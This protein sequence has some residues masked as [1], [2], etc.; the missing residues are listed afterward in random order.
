VSWGLQGRGGGSSIRSNDSPYILFS[1][2]VVM[3]HI[4]VRLIFELLGSA[5]A[6]I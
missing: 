2:L 1:F 4:S 5:S 6:R 3:G